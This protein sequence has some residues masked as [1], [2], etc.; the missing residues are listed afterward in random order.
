MG[1]PKKG[2]KRSMN[3]RDLGKLLKRH[4]FRIV[5]NGRGPHGKILDRHGNVVSAIV[6][7]STRQ[8]SKD[9]IG[10]VIKRIGLDPSDIF[11]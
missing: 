3:A 11:A 5:R 10:T 1:K 6:V 7:Q 2:G 4:G 9:Y 8:M